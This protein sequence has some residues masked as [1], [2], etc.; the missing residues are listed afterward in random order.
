MQQ[1]IVRNQGPI[2]EL[3]MPS[4]WLMHTEEFRGYGQRTL[5]QLV[6]IRQS[7]QPD[8]NTTISVF[9]RGFPVSDAGAAS[10]NQLLAQLKPGTSSKLLFGDSLKD[11]TEILGDTTAGDNQYTNPVQPGSDNVPMFFVQSAQLADLNGRTVL[12]VEGYFTTETGEPLRYF[13]G[14]FIDTDGTGAVIHEVFLQ[15]KSKDDMMMQKSVYR[16]ALKSIKWA[17]A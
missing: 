11:L 15:S 9:Y 12:A 13:S 16:N 1:L 5:I 8:W 14:V 6:P 10:F 4:S 3:S 2:A 7:D 17:D